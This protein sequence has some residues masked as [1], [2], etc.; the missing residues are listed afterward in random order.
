VIIH[1]EDFFALLPDD[2]KDLRTVP[3]ENAEKFIALLQEALPQDAS[4]TLPAP[5]A[6]MQFSPSGAH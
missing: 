4:F 2:P 3:T 6:W 1:W 5:G